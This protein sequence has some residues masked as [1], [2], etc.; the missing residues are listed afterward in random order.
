[1]RNTKEVRCK[2]DGKLLFKIIDDEYIE[3]VCS[4]CKRKLLYKLPKSLTSYIPSGRIV[5]K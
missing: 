2:N 1:M 3:I 5:L 4:K